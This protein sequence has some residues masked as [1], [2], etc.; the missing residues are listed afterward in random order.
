MVNTISF[1][2]SSLVQNENLSNLRS[3]LFKLQTQISTGKRATTYA[4]LDNRVLDLLSARADLSKTETYTNNIEIVSSRIEVMNTSMD[5]ITEFANDLQKALI[6]L[7]K[8]SEEPELT[9]IKALIDSNK[10]FIQQLLNTDINGHYLFSGSASNVEPIE[11]LSTLENNIQNEMDAWFNGT[12]TYD[13]T[14]ANVQALSGEQ[15]GYSEDMSIADNITVR[16]DDNLDVDYTVLANESG[17]QDLLK[18]MG[19]LGNLVYPDPND[20]SIAAT[21]D[22]FYQAIEDLSSMLLDSIESIEQSQIRLSY[23]NST[24]DKT[25]QRLV[26]E[27]QFLS[28][29]VNDIEEVDLSETIAKLQQVELQLNAS[30]Q[31]ISAV[32]QLSLANFI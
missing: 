24:I 11:N 32:S 12:Q 15:L 27:K 19:F 28:T 16:V 10:S 14:I 26:E 7:P 23:A 6:A 30:Y 1:L 13:Q 25:Q 31:T 9:H 22:E 29:I 4:G 8:T 17:F 5:S 21:G 2:G 18:I 20:G 3:D